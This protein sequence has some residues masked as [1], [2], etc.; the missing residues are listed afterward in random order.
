M[1]EYIK[2]YYRLINLNMWNKFIDWVESWID[3][4][5]DNYAEILG[6]SAIL[7]VISIEV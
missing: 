2:A 1:N 7:Y 3:H 6:E 4:N 5:A